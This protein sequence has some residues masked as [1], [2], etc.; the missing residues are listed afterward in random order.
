MNQ[1]QT[2]QTLVFRD[3]APRSSIEWLLAID[4]AELSWEIQRYHVL[5]HRLLSTSRQKAIEA[6]L[7]RIDVAVTPAELQRAAECYIAQNALDW[8]LDAGAARD[9]EARLAS[10]GFD[11]HSISMEAYVQARALLTLFDTLLDNARLR[12]LFLLRE[13]GRL[14]KW[15]KTRM[16]RRSHRRTPLTSV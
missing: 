7:H 6:T 1:Y 10:Y 3:L 9:I 4:I 11:Q 5:R 12:R 15:T 13:F 8:Q 2:L 16:A 14:Q